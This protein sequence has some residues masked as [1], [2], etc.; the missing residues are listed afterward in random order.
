MSILSLESVN[1]TM[2]GKRYFAGVIQDF[3]MGR[4]FWII[5]VGPI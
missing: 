2:Q 1:G 3:E 4:F 5:W